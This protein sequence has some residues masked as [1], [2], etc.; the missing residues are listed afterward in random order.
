[1][2]RHLFKIISICLL[3][4]IFCLLTGQQAGASYNFKLVERIIAVGDEGPDVALLQRKLKE[5][6]YYKGDIDGL[7]GPNT[8]NA[9]KKFQMN[10]GIRVDGI[11]GSETLSYLSGKTL[12]SRLSVDRDEIILLARIIHG[13][14]R[15][16]DFK[17]KVAVGAVVLNRVKNYKFPN[18][19]REVIL[20]EGQFSCLH[21]GQ[22][23]YY[24]LPGSIDAARAA[25]M[26]YDPTFNSLY[27]YNPEVA[28]RLKW[29]SKR[30]ITVRIGQH[31]FA[32]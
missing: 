22:A 3:I 30:P 18:S 32:R 6:S 28:T 11:I 7:Y 21:D 25:I 5:L 24:P 4:S 1:M 2:Y 23:N 14:A 12:L 9:V 19:I 20:Q 16:E 29:I 17:G 13:E 10:K 27:F 31:I 26:G 15:G 8:V